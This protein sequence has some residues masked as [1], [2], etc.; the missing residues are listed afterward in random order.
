MNDLQIAHEA[1]RLMAPGAV[2][3]IRAVHG[4]QADAIFGAVVGLL[5]GAETRGRTLT[6]AGATLYVHS[7]RLSSETIPSTPGVFEL[8]DGAKAVG[9]S[10][11][12]RV[13]HL[14]AEATT[15]TMVQEAASLLKR[16]GDLVAIQATSEEQADAVFAVAVELVPGEVHDRMIQCGESGNLR[17]LFVHVCVP[18][19]CIPRGVFLRSED[20]LGTWPAGSQSWQI[21][22]DPDGM[23]PLEAPG[24][25]MSR[26]DSMSFPAMPM[27]P[28][29][30]CGDGTVWFND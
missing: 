8:I 3:I 18:A 24:A 28:Y 25:R 14:W 12:A 11:H 4:P 7:L 20:T 21:W 16:H 6:Y 26:F 30:F 19:D 9:G 1:A 2:V 10:R 29:D 15:A 23:P 17:H 5:P 27:T 22:L 13:W